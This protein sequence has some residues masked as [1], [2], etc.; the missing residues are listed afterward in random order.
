[1]VKI[2]DICIEKVVDC[3]LKVFSHSLYNNLGRNFLD[4]TYLEI[5]NSLESIN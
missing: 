4:K 5:K 3:H 1:M 2:N